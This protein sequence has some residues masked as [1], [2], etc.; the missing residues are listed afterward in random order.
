MHTGHVR[1]KC[2]DRKFKHCPKSVAQTVRKT[3]YPAL[4]PD[5]W[6]C[7][8]CSKTL[9][10]GRYLRGQALASVPSACS[11]CIGAA[12]AAPPMAK[13]SWGGHYG[14]GTEILC[15]ILKVGGPPHAW[16]QG[17]IRQRFSDRFVQSGQ[18]CPNLATFPPSQWPSRPWIL[19]PHN[20]DQVGKI[21][22]QT[23]TAL[24]RVTNRG[25]FPIPR[26]RKKA[27]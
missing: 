26:S 12:R 9:P 25:F 24:Y 21:V 4:P 17:I 16:W 13:E 2:F 18:M 22:F 23:M 6:N 8:H 14:D 7:R 20:E 11:A 5:A 1:C 15:V 19:S 27:S 10:G 3:L